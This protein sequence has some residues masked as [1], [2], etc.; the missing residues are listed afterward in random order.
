MHFNVIASVNT[1]S[2][3][4]AKLKWR[5][6][7][8]KDQGNAQEV[9]IVAIMTAHTTKILQ[10]SNEILLKGIVILR[11]RQIMRW[12]MI[13]IINYRTSNLLWIKR[14]SKVHFFSKSRKWVEIILRTAANAI[15]NFTTSNM[16]VMNF[17]ICFFIL[18]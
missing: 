9:R 1:H 7:S 13:V 12:M 4:N 15:S 18:F 8:C 10:G 14:I 16:W 11:Q 3:M 2:V 6:K 5:T 17:F